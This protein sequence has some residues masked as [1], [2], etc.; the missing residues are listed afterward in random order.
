MRNLP[1]I[2][3]LLPVVALGLCIGGAQPATQVPTTA[4]FAVSATVS[5]GCWVVGNPGQTANVGFG[6][7]DFGTHSAAIGASYNAVVGVSS[8]S[9]AQVQCTP[10][11]TATMT[12]DGGL[13]ATG[14][15]RRMKLAPNYYVPY[16][17]TT[18][19]GGGTTVLPGVGVSIVPGNGPITLPVYGTATAPG[20]GVPGGQYSDTVQVVF[21]W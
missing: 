2:R 10:G 16:T 5:S 1:S 4:T 12:I 3:L 21:S 17:L 15:Q 18:A 14:N 11:V 13:N 6:M 9:P 8:G 19:P 20:T 7:L